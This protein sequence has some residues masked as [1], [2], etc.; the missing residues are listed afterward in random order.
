MDALGYNRDGDSGELSNLALSLTIDEGVVSILP[1]VGVVFWGFSLVGLG[2][3]V[4]WPL[5][6]WICTTSRHR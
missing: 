6:I 4:M 2:I 3:L 5:L 1:E